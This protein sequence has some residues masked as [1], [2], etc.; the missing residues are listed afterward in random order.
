ME[1]TK[2]ILI[3]D[4]EED[5][6]DV[7]Q[8]SLEETAGWTAASA[9]SGAEGIE[10]AAAEFPDAILLDVMM[11]GMDGLEVLERLKA[12][13]RTAGIPVILLTAKVQA[14]HRQTSGKEA[15]VILKPFDPLTLAPEIARMLGW[16][17]PAL[18]E[19][20]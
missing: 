15:G 1:M 17:E 5:I 9:R 4:D 16:L 12:D 19:E 2:R 14:A 10:T 7:A 13:G 6:R 3:I 18:A 11:P 8:I 20:T